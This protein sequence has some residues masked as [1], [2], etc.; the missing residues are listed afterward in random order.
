MDFPADHEIVCVQ[1][2]QIPVLI[3]EHD[4]PAGCEHA[5][6]FGKCQWDIGY[7]LVQSFGAVCVDATTSE[8]KRF[9][10]R[11]L[12]GCGY[13]VRQRGGALRRSSRR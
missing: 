2:G 9:D 5:P 12:K 6:C 1:H 3:D 8:W 7:M 13:A 10:A 11:F 4:A